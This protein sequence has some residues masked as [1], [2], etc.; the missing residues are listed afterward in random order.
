M[1]LF[2]RISEALGSKFI[3]HQ[4]LARI[5]SLAVASGKNVL[6][7][8]PGG[9]GKSEMVTAALSVVAKDDDVYVQSFGEGMDE[10][11]LWGGLDFAALERDKV[12]KYF[13]DQSFLAKDFAVFEEMFDAPATVLLALKDTLTAKKLRKGSQSYPM[14][15]KVIIAVTN[16]DPSEI[17]DLGPAAA[18]LIERFPLQYKVSW[19]SYTAQ[20]YLELFGKVAPQLRGA[21]LNGTTR[22]LAEVMAK[23]SE[24]GD[25]VSPRTA[26]HALGVVKAAAELRGSGKVEKQDLLDLCYLPGMEQFAANLKAELDAAY[27]RAEAEAR[28]SD[29]ERKLQTLLSEQSSAKDS[30]IKLLQVAKRLLAFQDEVAKLKV[31]DGLT[32]RRKRVRDSASEKAAEAQRMALDNTRA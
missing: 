25:V 28:L 11:T 10:A 18:A 3:R 4:E 5:L 13:P 1:N 16:K 12:L 14:K 24:N 17:A 26:V 20:D 31:T 19:P 7:W 6:L 27:E 2:V 32:D 8:G 29:A 22:V 23:A 9:H 30:P 15:T 21:D